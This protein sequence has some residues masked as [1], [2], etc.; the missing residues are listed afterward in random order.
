[1]VN[2]AIKLGAEIE[3]NTTVSSWSV[4]DDGKVEVQTDRGVFQAER[5]VLA[6]GAWSPALLPNLNLNL[7]VLRKQQQWFQIDR[8]DQ[9]LIN[10]FPSFLIEQSDGSVYYGIPEIDYLG[11]KV[12][13][14]SGGTLVEDPSE[15]NRE[16]DQPELERVEQF[17]KDH[18][19]FGHHRMVHYSVCMYAMST[20]SHFIVDRYPDLPQVSF[21]AGMSGHGF[22]FAPVIGRY[23]VDLLDGERDPDFE[24]LKFDRNS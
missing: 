6:G 7:R 11:M 19:V 8:V 15:M 18:L 14:H 4:G 3:T 16:L 1:M 5:L 13:E 20:D 23:L 10:G 21:A 2:Q 22:K 17:M 12:C 24:F 9:K